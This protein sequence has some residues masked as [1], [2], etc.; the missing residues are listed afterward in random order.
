MVSS[1][2]LASCSF[3]SRHNSRRRTSPADT[4][5]TATCNSNF[6]L[7]FLTVK[8]NLKLARR[9]SGSLPV[10]VHSSIAGTSDRLHNTEGSKEAAPWH[11]KQS[12]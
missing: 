9:T 12:E 2:S 3:C 1:C 8:S 6:W 10:G 7:G 11:T 5:L 4:G